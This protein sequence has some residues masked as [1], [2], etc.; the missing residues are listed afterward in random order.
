MINRLPIVNSYY[1]LVTV[2]TVL[3]VLSNKYQIKYI[4]YCRMILQ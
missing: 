4:S 3:V 1:N 2:K